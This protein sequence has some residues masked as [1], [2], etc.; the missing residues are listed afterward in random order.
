MRNLI[1]SSSGFIMLEMIQP[2]KLQTSTVVG[3]YV[4]SCAVINGGTIP[5]GTTVGFNNDIYVSYLCA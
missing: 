4:A 5:S 1:I 3:G 2:L